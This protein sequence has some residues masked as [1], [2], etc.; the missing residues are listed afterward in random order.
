MRLCSVRKMNLLTAAR[1]QGKGADLLLEGNVHDV[2]RPLGAKPKI[3]I[4]NYMA[5]AKRSISWIASSPIAVQAW[6]GHLLMGTGR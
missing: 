3:R 4:G 5:R 2:V 1:A 6:L